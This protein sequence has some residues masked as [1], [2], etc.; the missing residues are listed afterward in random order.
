MKE[1]EIVPFSTFIRELKKEYNFHKNGGT[2]FRQVTS[3]IALIVAIECEANRVD[4]FLD[5]EIVKQTVA[6]LMPTLNT[7]RSEDVTK[8]LCTI[9]KDLYLKANLSDEAKEYVQQ[10]QHN[11]KSLLLIKKLK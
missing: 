4:Y 3:L 5:R 6:D 10:K 7:E 11:Q 9:A 2:S 1:K 8:F